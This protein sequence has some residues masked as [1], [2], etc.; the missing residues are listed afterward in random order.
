MSVETR[1]TLLDQYTP[2]EAAEMLLRLYIAFCGNQVQRR[3]ATAVAQLDD[4]LD[5]VTYFSKDAPMNGMWAMQ[6]FIARPDKQS[7]GA[8]QMALLAIIESQAAVAPQSPSTPPSL[9]VEWALRSGVFARS[10]AQQSLLLKLIEGP[11][12]IGDFHEI[13]GTNDDGASVKSFRNR[14]NEYLKRGGW[15]CRV[16]GVKRMIL[17]GEQICPENKRKK[18]VR[19][20]T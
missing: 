13:T 8:A 12:E 11:V 10:T 5:D 2:I 6:Q 1:T 20:R 9:L 3:H 16:V 18:W 7:A 15:E 4:I 17:R 14:L 19:K